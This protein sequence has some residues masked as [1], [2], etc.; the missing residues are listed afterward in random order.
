MTNQQQA[1][2]ILKVSNDQSATSLQDLKSI[3]RPISNK[4]TRS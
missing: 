4:P 2:K 3:K 1:R